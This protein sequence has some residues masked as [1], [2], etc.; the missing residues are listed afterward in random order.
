MPLGSTEILDF[1]KSSELDFFLYEL[2]KHRDRIEHNSLKTRFG[3]EFTTANLDGIKYF[4]SNI[5]LI[6]ITTKHVLKKDDEFWSSNEKHELLFLKILKKLKKTKEHLKFFK[7]D[8]IKFYGQD[9]IFLNDR[10]PREFTALS[11][12][13]VQQKYLIKVK[14]THF[15][16]IDPK[17]LDHIFTGSISLPRPYIN[18]SPSQKELEKILQKKNELNKKYGTEAEKWVLNYE[19]NKF[20]GKVSNALFQRIESISEELSGA[21]FDIISLKSE[22]ST[23]PDKFIEVKS[24]GDKRI[25]F[26]SKNEMR[27]AQ[28]KKDNYFLYLIDRTNFN[29]KSYEP[30][31]IKNPFKKILNG[32]NIEKEFQYFNKESKILVESDSFLFNF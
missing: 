32:K 1:G 27:I 16:K 9:V 18:K 29:K 24:F 20:R 8:L 23:S 11:R 19:K 10:V 25:F 6:E 12:L 26:W 4:L 2:F 13:L 17:F 22:E 15:F 31:Q 28:E 21:G 5:D 30:M 14:D 3:K 7:E